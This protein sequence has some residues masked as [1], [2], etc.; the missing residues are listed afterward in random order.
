MCDELIP[1]ADV[2]CKWCEE[3][4]PLERD[5]RRQFCANGRGCETAYHNDLRSARNLLA[6]LDKTCRECAATFTRQT[7]KAIYCSRACAV[8][9]CGRARRARRKD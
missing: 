2:R 8:K 1:W 9:A 5:P 6:R 7:G 4:L 3:R